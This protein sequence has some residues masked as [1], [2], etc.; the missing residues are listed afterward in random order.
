MAM[1]KHLNSALAL[2][3][4][5]ALLAGVCCLGGSLPV[6][7]SA[8]EDPDYYVLDDCD[9]KTNSFSGL[10]EDTAEKVQGKASLRG[11]VSGEAT[12]SSSGSYRVA[13]PANLKDWYLEFWL[14]VDNASALTKSNCIVELN[15]TNN[16]IY[17]RWK[18]SKVTLVNGWN[19]IQLKVNG[20]AEKAGMADFQTIN[21][22]KFTFVSSRQVNYH[23]DDV[24]LAKSNVASSKAVVEAALQ[25]AATYDAAALQGK[26]QANIDAFKAAKAAAESALASETMS[27]RDV[28]LAAEV[29]N[30]RMNA[31]GFE[32]Y[33]EDLDAT[34][35]YIDFATKKYYYMDGFTVSGGKVT[36]YNGRT[37]AEIS[38]KLQ[39]N[40]AAKYIGDSSDLRISFTYF[41]GEKGGLEVKYGSTDGVKT[42]MTLAFTGDK[43][44]KTTSVRVQD[45]ALA[46]NVDGFDLALSATGGATAYVSRVDIHTITAS[47]LAEQPAPEFA[48]QTDSNNII[49]AATAGYQLWFS[50]A[51]ADAGW[52]HWGGH[53]ANPSPGNGNFSF[54]V[55]P[56]TKDYIDNGATLYESHLGALGNGDKSVLFN[57]K[58]DEIVDTH[59]QWISEYGIDCL[60]VQRFGFGSN[61]NKIDDAR[62]HLLTVMKKAEKYDKTFYVMYDVSG[63]GTQSYDDFYA[64][65][66]NDWVL[67]VEQP[68]VASS[69]AYAHAEGKPVVCIWGITGNAGDTNYPGGDTAARV[70]RWFQE[71]GYYV[72]IG[73]PD[74]S[75]ATRTGEYLEP[76]ILADMISPWTVGRY[77]ENSVAKWLQ[78]NIATDLAFGEKYDNEYQPVIFP[79][80]SWAGMENG[81]KP[82]DYPRN[83]G[84]FA[85]MQA[86]AIA[87]AGVNTIYFAMFD[88][89]DEG[90]AWMKGAADSF[91]IPEAQYFVTYAADGYWLSND[92]YLRLAGTIA[93]LTQGE[94][95]DT[96]LNIPYSQGPVYWRNSFEKRWTTYLNNNKK[97][98]ILVNTDVC[99][100]MNTVLT[101]YTDNAEISR[102]TYTGETE[103]SFIEDDQDKNKPQYATSLEGTGIFRDVS[104][105]FTKTGEWAFQLQGTA[106]SSGSKLAYAIAN[107][108]ITVPAAGL[109]LSYALYAAN[110]LGK[111]VYVDFMMEDP[112]GGDSFLLSDKVASVATA[113]GATGKWTDVKIKLPETLVGLKITRALICFKS[114]TGE[115]NAYVDDIALQSV[116][117]EKV[118][119]NNA[120]TTTAG[121]VEKSEALAA[122]VKAGQEVLNGTNPKSVM[123]KAMKEIDNVIRDEGLTYT[124]KAPTPADG[125][126]G[127]SD[128]DGNI[129][130]TDARLALQYAA[131]KID[132]TKLN[133][134][135]ADVDTTEGVTTTDARLIL[136]KAAKKIDKFPKEA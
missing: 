3:L 33:T 61:G 119:L 79:G 29:L 97:Y 15:Q 85:W 126:L 13:A 18:L 106:R 42:A 22:V 75:Y 60:A 105:K 23:I 92:Y 30:E 98:T 113:H 112:A 57:S 1:K 19:K 87:K 70:V 73:T 4:T 32:G 100:P 26:S 125:L 77:R 6:L 65:M 116:G 96:E 90:T 111:N 101:M 12:I 56:Y 20:A 115:F 133:T 94:R 10:V 40:T 27:Q 43:R 52:V 69:T 35:S 47:D 46:R 50:A 39:L 25:R 38:K 8:A 114:G 67:N 34:Y 68:G 58:D 72:I 108:N 80:F 130:T 91:E 135:L 95:T 48:A 89:Y 117:S 122:A 132:E 54:D 78:S 55:Y 82:N 49:G 118:M 28:D 129:T 124:G 127:D 59:F 51:E 31:F 86:T 81:G 99:T 136:Q 131:K 110:D 103:Y 121:M 11:S 41:D 83:A 45:A 37:A 17:V 7:R 74:N 21:R 107:T 109:E 24:C 53:T 9:T 36:G 64:K 76:F 62:N 102:K 44:W 134:A 123:L 66:T 88:E 71:R 104:K 84:R 120:I 128:E 16:S 14:H 2:V 63:Q 5:L 93:A